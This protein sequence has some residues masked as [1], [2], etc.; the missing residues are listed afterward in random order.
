MTRSA[1]TPAA[2]SAE[3][4]DP[5]EERAL[6]VAYRHLRIA[7]GLLALSLP[8]AIVLGKGLLDG[9]W[10]PQGSISA[11]YYTSSRNY[12]VGALC[13]LAVFFL[14]YEYR[15]VDE[16]RADNLLSNLASVAALGVAFLPTTRGG[17]TSTGPEKVVGAL[18]YVCAVALFVILAVFCLFRFT[19]SQGKKT[20]QKVLRNRVYRACGGVIVGCL[21]LCLVALV[22]MPDSWRALFWLESIMVCAFALSWLVK[23]GFRGTLEDK[24]PAGSPA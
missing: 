16:F 2:R 20:P 13:A 22:A 11:Y 10:V 19:L 9:S 6:S 14:S 7:I 12:F 18:H 21:I 5:D 1:D 24:P 15:S 3:V 8:F 17:V 4:T 23:G